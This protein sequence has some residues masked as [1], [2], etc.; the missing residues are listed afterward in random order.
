LTWRRRDLALAAA[1][2]ALVGLTVWARLPG[3]LHESLWADEVYSARTI[4][5]P[6]TR[7]ALYRVSQESS[8][9]GWFV[10]ARATHALGAEPQTVR[11]LSVLFSAA[12]TVLVVLY[13]RRRLPLPG[14]LLAGLL[15][16][17]AYQPVFHGK[18]LRPYAL[19]ALLALGFVMALERAAGRPTRGR[20]VLLAAISVAGALTHYFFLLAVAVGL[21]WLWLVGPR[22]RRGAL[23]AAVLAGLVP[24]LA[25]V[26]KIAGQAGRVDTYF[27]QVTWDRVLWLYSNIV[28]SESVWERAGDGLRYVVLGLVL[29]GAVV[30]ACRREGRLAA[31]MV[32][33]PVAV[34]A[35]V[36]LAGLHVFTTRNLIVVAP[37]ACIALAA[38]PSAI[39]WR[40]LALAATIAVAVGAV[41]SFSLDRQRDRTPY[42]RV[43]EAI[44][45]FAWTGAEPV[46]FVGSTRIDL[47]TTA[48]VA[49]NQRAPLGWHLRGHPQLQP[50]RLVPSDCERAYVVAVSQRGLDWL[51]SHPDLVLQ[52][53]S[54]PYYGRRS[55][56]ERSPTD[57]VVAEV[58]W[59]D[60]LVKVAR[61][62][63]SAL[64]FVRGD[65][66][67]ACLRPK[68]W[69]P[70][71]GRLF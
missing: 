8:P 10:L 45:D 21:L 2:A 57:L 28:S 11:L 67:P 66:P 4:V 64:F 59:T 9:P 34:T 70:G 68:P 13:A 65:A 36:S 46:V 3:A 1:L 38:V 12:L 54:L 47:E 61:S 53:R 25:W 27:S 6:S 18:E 16:A 29:A 22:A 30:L 39:P 58:I 62:Y 37:F 69:P 56:G 32:V 44:T 14:A 19:L 55:D 31:L 71:A 7:E 17:L 51:A 26:P 52:E 33:V 23:T 48:Q 50:A 20:L 63:G 5:E 24:L 60:E 35:A 49:L 41:W 42:D 40:P 43:G 15:A